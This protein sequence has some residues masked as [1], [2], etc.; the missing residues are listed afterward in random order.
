MTD[1]YRAKMRRAFEQLKKE[2]DEEK[3]PAHVEESSD[4]EEED[5]SK[6]EIRK[7]FEKGTVKKPRKTPEETEEN[8]NYKQYVEFENETEPA[9]D[10]TPISVKEYL[11]ELDEREAKMV[12]SGIKSY[13]SIWK[14]ASKLKNEETDEKRVRGF[15][16]TDKIL[17]YAFWFKL[18]HEG[19]GR[20]NPATGEKTKPIYLLMKT[21]KYPRKKIET[22]QIY[23]YFSNQVSPKA[24]SNA[25]KPCWV[26]KGAPEANIKKLIADGEGTYVELGERPGRMKS[27]EPREKR[28]NQKRQ[29]AK[30]FATNKSTDDRKE[31]KPDSDEEEEEQPRRK[32]LNPR[33]KKGKENENEDSRSEKR[34]VKKKRGDDENVEVRKYEPDEDEEPEDPIKYLDDQYRDKLTEKQKKTLVNGLKTY[35][36]ILKKCKDL[37]KK[38]GKFK[39]NA[40]C[41]TDFNLGM[42]FWVDLFI[43]GYGR[44]NK[45]GS[46][47]KPFYLIM[48][49]E[50]CPKTGR[51]HIQGYI[52]FKNQVQWGTLA[53][54]INPC[55]VAACKGSVESNFKYCSKD[56]KGGKADFVEFGEKPKGQGIR[57]DM[58]EFTQ[59]I[60]DTGMS[61]I[62]M[63]RADG[64]KFV[65]YRKSLEALS[66]MGKAEQKWKK[67][68]ESDGAQEIIAEA[69]G[70]VKPD[71]WEYGEDRAT[72]PYII[73]MRGK[74]NAGK[75]YFAL[76]YYG[77]VICK[78]DGT[79]VQNYHGE[80]CVVFNDLNPDKLMKRNP[81]IRTEF[82]DLTDKYECV[83]NVKG[84]EE[85]WNAV[86]IIFT[87]NDDSRLWLG[88]DPAWHKRVDKFFH[89]T[90]EVDEDGNHSYNYV[91]EYHPYDRE[92]D[93]QKKNWR[94]F[95][96]NDNEEVG[97]FMKEKADDALDMMTRDAAKFGMGHMEYMKRAAELM[98]KA[99]GEKF[100][101][102]VCE[103]KSKK[104]RDE[105]ENEEED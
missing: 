3:T 85:P 61:K 6:K 83:V 27:D 57:S 94:Q 15:Y 19:Y 4:V 76:E 90:H 86:V 41:F 2:A 50:V 52:Y 38:V 23:V 82:L 7:T 21:I 34:N 43:D 9:D 45:D 39:S 47:T 92:K 98:R 18:F 100:V 20:V 77:A 12:K 54:T 91:E 78:W 42:A 81:A 68:L 71:S 73:C 64:A 95:I 104:S 66:Q 60:L 33:P 72:R 17:G 101:K 89:A 35:K 103:P 40:F 56:Y 48:N 24:F 84:S 32:S 49:N 70:G 75:T 8:E 59:E 30:S 62:K 93:C 5:T 67:F 46:R 79:F 22:I 87:T 105:S 53:T 13:A 29:F 36:S 14:A 102:K 44:L 99:Q 88:G 80:P 55:W 11:E 74:P 31:R 65:Q 16:I 51:Q 96:Q 97:W 69:C 25:L 63:A 1:A 10:D 26:G 37:P 58:H 28:E